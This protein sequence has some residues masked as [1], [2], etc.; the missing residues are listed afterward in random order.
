MGV[1]HGVTPTGSTRATYAALETTK[2]PEDILN[3]EAIKH[4]K[5]EKGKGT[6]RTSSN[7]TKAL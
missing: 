7:L 5:R 3:K 4:S 6:G 2:N 1:S